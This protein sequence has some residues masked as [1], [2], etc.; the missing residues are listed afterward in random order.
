MLCEMRDLQWIIDVSPIVSCKMIRRTTT[1]SLS[2]IWQK[3]SIQ[4]YL[5]HLGFV[6]L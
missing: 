1:K 5:T 4:I 3:K 6:H 2:N